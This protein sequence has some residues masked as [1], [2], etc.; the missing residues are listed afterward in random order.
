MKMPEADW[1][2]LFSA[3]LLELLGS[4]E[5]SSELASASARLLVYLKAEWCCIWL[6]RGSPG[7]L[8]LAGAQHRE[9]GKRVLVERLATGWPTKGDSAIWHEVMD[10]QQLLA[11]P[12]H[13]SFQAREVFGSEDRGRIA[14][15]LG[16]SSI[17][18]APL[19]YRGEVLGMLAV[20]LAGTEDGVAA[21]ASRPLSTALFNIQQ[22]SRSRAA[23]LQHTLSALRLQTIVDSMPQGVIVAS[24]PEGLVVAA[25]RSL[26]QLLG[27]EIEIAAPLSRYSDLF[28]PAAM[29]DISHLPFELPWVQA[30]RTGHAVPAREMIVKR[31][32]ASGFTVSCSATPF[33][34]ERGN[35][36]GVVAVLQDVSDRKEF[37]RE[38]QDLIGMVSHELK[39][40]LT[41]LKSSAQLLRRRAKGRNT[42]PIADDLDEILE[43]IERQTYRLSRLAN[44]MVAYSSAR[45]GALELEPTRFY[46]SSLASEV[47]PGVWGSTD[48]RKLEI[49][50]RSEAPV[51][52]DRQL[53]EQALVNLVS[54]AF[55]VTHPGGTVVVSV[56]EEGGSVV[57]SVRDEG[58]GVP[59][60]SAEQLFKGFYRGPSQRHEGMGLGLYVVRSIVEA[61]DGKIWLES[62]PGKGTTFFFSLPRADNGR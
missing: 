53:I 26:T 8:E 16:A 27:R 22:V 2:T 14:R 56:F 5:T 11:V 31:A 24:V 10:R 7:E 39:T 59:A 47:L 37:E 20:A 58:P 30:A 17:T 21:G 3:R 51:V 45:T 43:I 62:T 46:L 54:N 25:N 48:D 52:A 44:D 15:D 36:I 34:D 18:L 61:H 19:V 49:A 40:P 9:A 6:T 23:S 12:V 42:G 33:A 41:S 60:K 38:R 35:T 55:K 32:D 57:V 28:E 50:V 4:S 29:P 1:I 13:D